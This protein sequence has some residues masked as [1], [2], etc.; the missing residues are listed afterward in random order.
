[1]AYVSIEADE[2]R[3]YV[4]NGKLRFQARK[5]NCAGEVTGQ[6]TVS[7]PVELAVHFRQVADL[8][9]DISCEPRAKNRQTVSGIFSAMNLSMQDKNKNKLNQDVID[10]I[11]ESIQSID[12]GEI[13]I[14]VHDARVVQIEKKVK[15]RFNK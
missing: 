11:V 7:L 5:V 1:M 13:L 8:D 3:A 12:F 9:E 2:C 15:K 10:E 4:K 6:V 14:V